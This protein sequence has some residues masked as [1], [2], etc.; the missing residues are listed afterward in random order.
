MEKGHERF[1]LFDG[2]RAVAAT[3][4]FVFHSWVFLGLHN[5]T[6]IGAAIEQIGITPLRNISTLSAHL[7]EIGVAL[8]YFLSAFLLFR[9]F[10]KEA[11][12]DGRPVDIKGYAIRRLARIVPAY[13]L[14]LTVIGLTDPETNLFSWAGVVNQYL[15][16]GIYRSEG[17]FSASNP[18]IASW[19]VQVEMSFYVFLPIWA[20]L[21]IWLRRRSA[22]PLRAE[23]LALTSLALIG[24]AWKLVAVTQVKDYSALGGDDWFGS[25]F[26]VL[27]A[28]IDVFAIGMAL[29]LVSLMPK[30]KAAQLL[31]KIGDKGV[32]CWL[33]AAAL[34]LLLCWLGDERGPFHGTPRS[35]ALFTSFLKTPIALLIM[36][37]AV[38]YTKGTSFVA[39][40]L[41]WKP[42]VWIGT[43]SYGLYLWQVWV[44]R[45]LSGPWLGGGK[46]PF[47]EIEL[48]WFGGEM[49]AAYVI[50]LA[51]AALSWYL[52]E[53]RALAWGHAVSKRIEARN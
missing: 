7:G 12:A 47:E 9:P 13:W 33:G 21:M 37:P 32:L 15:F 23:L 31:R 6:T 4:V 52:L 8:F 16:L 10:A 46:G 24:I 49:V 20:G 42:V 3:L 36:L 53:K 35:I 19:T 39:R 29:S 27:P 18:Y 28:S 41:R 50:T 25:S 26:A 2:L 40:T 51:I 5:G 30:T 17:L 14:V 11:W 22:R 38:Y 43:V 1:P 44:T 34:Y 45:H 48:K